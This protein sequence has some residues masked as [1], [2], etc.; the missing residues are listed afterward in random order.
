MTTTRCGGIHGSLTNKLESSLPLKLRIFERNLNISNG[1]H[2][3]LGGG[4]TYSG[5][6]DMVD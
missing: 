5:G 4:E 2:F 1:L 6:N 3:G